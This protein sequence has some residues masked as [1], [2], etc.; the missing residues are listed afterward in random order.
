MARD[1]LGGVELVALAGGQKQLSV[2]REDD[3]AAEMVWP[4]H[5][6]LLAEDDLE[7]LNA[8]VGQTTAPKRR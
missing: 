1:V 7:G 4:G 8:I 5:F 3:S 6:R 2:R